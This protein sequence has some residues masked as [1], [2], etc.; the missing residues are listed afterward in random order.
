MIPLD[1]A[2]LADVVGGELVDDADAGRVV[3]SVTIDS[4]AVEPGA[5][6]VPLPGEHADGHRFIGDAVGRGATG[7]LLADDRE[8]EHPGAVAVDDPADALTGLG[9]WVRD[10]VDPAVVAITGSQGKTTTKDLIAVAA[11][12]SDGDAPGL[13]T[14]SAPGSYN[15]D[16]G[17]PLTLCLLQADS[18]VLVTEM[19]TRGIGHIARLTPVARPTIAV[20]TAVGAS[21][22]ELLG[23]VDNVA[24]AK[25][26]LVEG[27]SSDGVAIL[28][29]DDHR[30]AA[31]AG[32]TPARVVTYGVEADADWRARDVRFDDLARPV[33]RVEGPD[34]AAAEV[35]L[36]VLGG[37]NV[38]N[39][40]AAIAV[41][42]ELGVAP[43]AAAAALATAR[44]SRWRMELIPTADGLV[45]LNDAYNA[46]PG[47]TRAALAAFA[48]MRVAGRRWAVLGQMGELGA[49]SDEAHLDIGRTAAR[50]GLDGLVVV[51][52]A[53]AGIGAGASEVWDSEL[54]LVTVADRDAA[55]AFLAE[56]LGPDDAVLVKAS[57]AV[58]L[59]RVADAL[60]AAH[61]GPAPA[62]GGAA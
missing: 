59:E 6:F 18:E 10:T 58:G 41:A 20:V 37:H 19:G 4:R 34:G 35:R 31:M 52:E 16:L 36:A 17:V 9:A 13:R 46:N 11:A 47:S 12:A 50:S 43:G 25:A 60:V 21:H 28:N 51:G 49:T 44:V 40:L 42:A 1:L 24:I 2:D 33:F 38:S 8:A 29:A 61:G 7:H 26:E 5:L 30:V 56:R 22:L 32:K 55:L 14:V 62:A 39:A 48:R 15:N 53:A 45:V 23:S 3:T 57:R 54:P 27:L